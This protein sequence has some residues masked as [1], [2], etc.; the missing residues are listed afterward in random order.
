MF[1]FPYGAQMAGFANN[2]GGNQGNGGGGQ[3]GGGHQQQQTFQAPS[4]QNMPSMGAMTPFGPVMLGDMN[5]NG[6]NTPRNN[7]NNGN[8]NNGGRRNSRNRNNSNGNNNNNNGGGGRL[9]QRVDDLANSMSP[10]TT[11]IQKQAMAAEQERQRRLAEEQQAQAAKDR[12]KEL[13]ALSAGI[14]K[15]MNDSLDKNSD[16]LK[17]ELEAV[18]QRLLAAPSSPSSSRGQK[19]GAGSPTGSSGSNCNGNGLGGGN[20]LGAGPGNGA[21]AARPKGKA[22]AKASA[23]GGGVS[24]EGLMRALGRMVLTPQQATKILDDCECVG[25]DLHDLADAKLETLVSALDIPDFGSRDEWC[26]ADEA[27][28]GQPRPVA[29]MHRGQIIIRMAAKSRGF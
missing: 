28:T 20:G 23:G 29:R 26:D 15:T 4:F 22:K 3:N 10:V 16:A 8:N 18:K 27:F 24:E 12:Q 9:G 19:R 7:N 11:L 5:T 13:E 14:L 21:R 1:G 2:Q 17:N 6:F 25:I